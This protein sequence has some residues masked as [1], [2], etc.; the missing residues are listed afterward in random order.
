MIASQ[1]T[2]DPT[3]TKVVHFLPSPLTPSD[4]EALIGRNDDEN[5]FFGVWLEDTLIGVLD[6]H[7]HGGDR[8]EIGHWIGSQFQ[9]RGYAT[10]AMS[11]V[12]AQL[13][14]LY[15][16]RLTTAECRRGNLASW[17]LLHKL[18]SRPARHRN[19]PGRDLLVLD[20]R[21]GYLG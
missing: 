8:L 20:P 5:C 2:G 14:R 10:E 4:A 3:I 7:T 16:A 13:R 19:R 6:A 9:R 1:L 21:Q 18:G 15:L 12:I 11:A 17:D